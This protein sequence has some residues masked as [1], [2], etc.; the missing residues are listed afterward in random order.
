MEH[1]VST[2]DGRRLRVLERGAPDGQAVLV[3]NGTPNSSLLYEPSVRL[4]ERQGIRMLS[5]DRPGYG[6]SDRDPERSVASC[7]Q[8]V[9]AIADALEIERLAVWGIPG[10]GPHAVACAA[11][12]PDLVPAVAVLA[13][14]A[15]WGAEGLEYFEGMGRE[16]VEDW[17]L[18]LRDPA[19]G[20]VKHER[21][22]LGAVV[23]RR[24]G[25]WS[26]RWPRSH[27]THAPT[28]F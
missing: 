24:A 7:A 20:R 13:S 5:Y 19:A 22:R 14:I 26:S 3:H 1:Q 16:N 11:L 27:P 25:K 4:A 18:S 2:A 8:D 21:D 17:E 15:P 23:S 9:R 12:L 28:P 6:G 10:G